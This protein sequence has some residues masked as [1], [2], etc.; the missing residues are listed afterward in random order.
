MA[1]VTETVIARGRLGGTGLRYLLFEASPIDTNDTVTLN[2]LS[3]I[4]AVSCFRL[5]TGASI[6][7]TKATNVVTITQASLTDV[8]I[9]GLA[10]GS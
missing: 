4:T 9:V 1:D 10:T 7:S 6:T 5:D 2:E 3:V 8:L